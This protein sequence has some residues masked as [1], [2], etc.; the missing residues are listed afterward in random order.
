MLDTKGPE[1]RTGSL[2]DAEPVQFEKGEKIDILTD[3]ELEGEQGRLTC[4]YKSLPTTVRPD[5][6]ILIA[7]GSLT[8]KVLECFEDY[9]K[10]ECMNSALIGEKKNM[11]LP[12]CNVDLPTLTE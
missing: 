1:I 8:C 7:D 4:N 5:D 9:V 3:E 11:N 2:R 6:L 12:G 10:C